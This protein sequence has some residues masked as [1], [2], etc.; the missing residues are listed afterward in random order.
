MLVVKNMDFNFVL[1]CQ[2]PLKSYRND[3]LTNLANL[4]QKY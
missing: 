2:Y 1:T 4:N 3:A